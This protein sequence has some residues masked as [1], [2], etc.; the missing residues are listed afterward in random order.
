[1]NMEDVMMVIATK[2]ISPS[3]AVMMIQEIIRLCKEKE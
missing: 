3:V 1:M 2:D